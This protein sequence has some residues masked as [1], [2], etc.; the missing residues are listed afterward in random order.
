MV[1]PPLMSQW[2]TGTSRDSDI[3]PGTEGDSTRHNYADGYSNIGEGSARKAMA[4]WAE[5]REDY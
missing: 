4:R 2:K 5:S 1:N 3:N